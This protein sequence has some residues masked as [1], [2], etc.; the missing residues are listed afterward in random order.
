[1]YL[2]GAYET[3]FLNTDTLTKAYQKT[4]NTFSIKGDILS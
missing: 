3:N 4:N 2:Y 1:M